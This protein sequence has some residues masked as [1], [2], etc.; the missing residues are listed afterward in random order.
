MKS[1]GEPQGKRLLEI[2]IKGFKSIRNL[3]RLSLNPGINVLI[4]ANGAGKSN[5]ISFFTLLEHMAKGR[6]RFFSRRNGGADSLMFG[7]DVAST[8]EGDLHFEKNNG[9]RF[10]LGA[11]Y[12]GHLIVSTEET[13]VGGK[14]RLWSDNNMEPCLA[15]WT[16][17][18]KNRGRWHIKRAVASWQVY[19]FSY[20]DPD[21]PLRRAASVLDY[22]SG[23]RLHPRGRNLSAFLWGLQQ[24]H[25]DIY[26]KITRHMRQVMP[27]FSEFDLQQ[28]K[29]DNNPGHSVVWLCWKQKNSDYRFKPWQMSDGALRFLALATVLLQPNPP[30]TIIIDEPELGLHPQALNVFAGLM[31][32]AAEAGRQIIITTQ[33]HRLLDSMDPENI[34]TVNQRKGESFFERLNTEQLRH[35]L[36]EYTL[37]ELAAQ[38]IIEAGV[39]YV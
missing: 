9:Y 36:E 23:D 21:A 34:V 1:Q 28:V 6:M 20:T 8:I 5:F 19:H 10:A 25:A 31:H 7:G 17:V 18:N 30:A 14:T 38:N 24:N 33:N 16:D 27:V 11:A 12:D 2:S 15:T 35:W 37:G 4:G 29:D 26:M 13:S 32:G 3:E 39:N 22:D